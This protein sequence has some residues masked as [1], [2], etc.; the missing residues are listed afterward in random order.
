MTTKAATG[1]KDY[2][3]CICVKLLILVPGME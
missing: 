3:F 1:K 2:F